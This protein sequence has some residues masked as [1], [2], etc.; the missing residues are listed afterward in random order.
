[1][2]NANID[3][4][5]RHDD[6]RTIGKRRACFLVARDSNDDR[7]PIETRQVVPVLQVV[8]IQHAAGDDGAAENLG[9]L[10]LRMQATVEF[11]PVCIQGSEYGQVVREGVWVGEVGLRK[12]FERCEIEC[13]PCVGDC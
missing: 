12:A 7:G 1:M 2:H 11:F 4:D 5:I 6:F 9:N 3:Q 8:K 13:F 10:L